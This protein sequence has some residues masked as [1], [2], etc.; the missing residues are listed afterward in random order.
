VLLKYL[1]DT[2]DN[3]ICPIKLL[4]IHALRHGYL[5][6][7][8]IDEVLSNAC[9]RLDKQIIWKNGQVPVFCAVASFG[10]FLLLDEPATIN[11]ASKF[12][13]QAA[14][15]CGLH[16]PL[17]AHDLRRGAARDIAQIKQVS[18]GWQHLMYRLH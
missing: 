18:V 9:M 4:L 7:K 13:A 14:L 16:K 3:V 1:P 12:V 6:G 11:Q 8:F 2:K 5:N 15:L 17:V 10:A